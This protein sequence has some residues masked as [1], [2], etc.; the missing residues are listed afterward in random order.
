MQ[1]RAASLAIDQGTR[2]AFDRFVF[3]MEVLV[4]LFEAGTLPAVATKSRA[5]CYIRSAAGD[6][7]SME[8]C[9]RFTHCHATSPAIL[10]P[11]CLT[12]PGIAIRDK[13]MDHPLRRMLRSTK[14]A[15][16]GSTRI[17]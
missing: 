5:G 16:Q 2:P 17:K 12:P 1:L 6:T 3:V 8:R 14:I 7:V 9:H 10:A 4:N 15:R 13:N 11:S